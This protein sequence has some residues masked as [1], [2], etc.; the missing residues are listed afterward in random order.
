MMSAA[1][2]DLRRVVMGMLAYLI[3]TFAI[4][5]QGWETVDVSRRPVDIRVDRTVLEH[6]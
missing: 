2:T 4:A 1:R 3:P 6:G 5:H